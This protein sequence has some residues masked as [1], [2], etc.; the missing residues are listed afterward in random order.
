[1]IEQLIESNITILRLGL[2]VVRRLTDDQYANTKNAEVA[3]AG[4]HFRH[5]VDHYDCFLNGVASGRIDYD[6]RA[7]DT[8]VEK[9][10]KHAAMIIAS[11]MERLRTLPLD[12]ARLVQVKTDCGN[13]EPGWVTSTAA[14]ELQFLVSHT[15]HHYSLV[16][17]ALVAWGITIDPSFG[18]A[19]STLRFRGKDSCA[20]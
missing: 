10:P 12:S 8:A 16:R 15:V 1:M 17:I 13:E 20:R 19:P 6:N 2:N 5:I 14:R 4:P 11:V 3:A 18:V 9:D 7:R